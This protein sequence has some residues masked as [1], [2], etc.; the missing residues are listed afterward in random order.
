[1][2]ATETRIGLVEKVEQ[3]NGHQLQLWLTSSASGWTWT[4][5]MAYVPRG[6]LVRACVLDSGTEPEEQAARAKGAA[7]LERNKQPSA[8]ADAA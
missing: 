7:A 2:N 8:S 4:V 3:P 6:V 5:K 1:M